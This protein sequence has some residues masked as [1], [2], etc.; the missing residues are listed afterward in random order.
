MI[1]HRFLLLGLLFT[2]VTPLHAEDQALAKAAR[3]VVQENVTNPVPVTLSLDRSAYKEGELPVITVQT[4]RDCCVTLFY[5][6]AAGTL[7][8]LLPNQFIADNHLKGGAKTQIFP[9]ANPANASQKV[10]IEISGPV[11]GKEHFIVFAGDDT[12]PIT[13]AS[14]KA[15]EA[16]PL[17]S[18]K[19][20]RVVSMVRRTET[21]TAVV[22]PS[23]VTAVTGPLSATG[24]DGFARVTVVTTKK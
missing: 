23:A 21:A 7:V 17:A 20:A 6:D 8:Q 19:G 22:S 16:F 1:T 5:E 24:K 13:V 10:A 2:S 18:T 12:T 3:V 15:K 4:E 14:E 11:F 9:V